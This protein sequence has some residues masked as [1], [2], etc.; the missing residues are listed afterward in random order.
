MA[1]GTLVRIRMHPR[2]SAAKYLMM[3]VVLLVFGATSLRAQK[4]E[5]GLQFHLAVA[6]DLWCA[7]V[8]RNKLGIMRY[9][10]KDLPRFDSG[11][12]DLFENVRI[13][14]S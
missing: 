7:D 5:F 13:P 11:R 12:P 10:L 14:P 3:C 2:L 4:F 9:L 6:C 8:D 1:C